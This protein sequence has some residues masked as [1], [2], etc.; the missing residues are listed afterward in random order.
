MPRCLLALGSNLGDRH[1]ILER[2]C[3]EVAALSDCELLA[4]STWHTTAPIGGAGDQGAFL[5]G[6]ILVETTLE[7]SALAAALQT[8]ETQLGRERVVRWDARTIDIDMLLYDTQ[9]IDTFKL[10]VPHPRMAFRSFVLEPAAEIAGQMLHP[11]SGWTIARLRDHLQK[12]PRYLVVT[13]AEKQ[14]SEWLAAQLRQTFGCPALKR[15]IPI[16]Q[17]LPAASS[18]SPPVVATLL[19]SELQRLASN[20]FSK[21]EEI[22]PALVIILDANNPQQLLTTAAAAGF[23]VDSKPCQTPSAAEP[24]YLGLGPLARITAEDP[25][26]VLQEAL[27]AVRCVW[28]DIKALE[29]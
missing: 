18:G 17:Q 3:A 8:I 1:A 29:N 19:P 9:I 13:A 5:N 21:I 4:R 27:A 26:T 2:A 10:I 24:S 28:S 11:T 20:S 22:R 23:V 16:A 6:A 7:P 12:S 25:A 15:E 14:L